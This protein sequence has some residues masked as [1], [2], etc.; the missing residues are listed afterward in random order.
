MQIEIRRID[1]VRP[2]ERNPRRNDQAVQAVA[3]SIRTFGFRQ[4]VVVDAEGVI[5][6]GHTRYLAAKHLSLEEIPVHVAA[7]LTPEQAKAYRL[8]D[9]RTGELAG[10]DYDLLPLELADLRE[11]DACTGIGWDEGE[12]ERLLAVADEAPLPETAAGREFDETAADEVDTITCPECG[13]E[14]PR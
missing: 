3:E 9:N 14:F 2:Y 1:Q 10:W 6:A 12:I 13:H 5:V 11:V 7:D 8:A 4:P